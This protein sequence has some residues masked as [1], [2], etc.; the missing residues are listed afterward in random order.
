MS[1]PR[2]KKLSPN[3][4]A[5]LAK[6]ERLY[7]DSEIRRLGLV[8]FLQQY[9]SVEA[10]IIASKALHEITRSYDESNRLRKVARA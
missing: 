2:R 3:Q 6:A 8:M 7:L 4:E 5:L 10:F 9:T 1:K